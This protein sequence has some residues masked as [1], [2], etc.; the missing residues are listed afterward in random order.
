M[1]N[2]AFFSP[3]HVSG[4]VWSCVDAAVTVTSQ[5]FW[6]HLHI[7]RP[8][9]QTLW[10]QAL[11]EFC[12][13]NVEF[14]EIL[15]SVLGAACKL[16]AL[17]NNFSLHLAPKECFTVTMNKCI[18]QH[19]DTHKHRE[20]GRERVTLLHPATITTQYV[21]WA[22]TTELSKNQAV[23]LFANQDM[24][25]LVWIN[26]LLKQQQKNIVTYIHVQTGILSH[27]MCYS[28]P[29]LE[30]WGNTLFFSYLQ[31]TLEYRKLFP[32]D[33]IQTFMQN[34]WLMM[35]VLSFS[36]SAPLVLRF[37]DGAESHPSRSTATQSDRN[38]V[39]CTD[40]QFGG[41]NYLTM[42]NGPMTLIQ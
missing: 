6:W 12:S 3:I 24:A 27:S 5:D 35:T 20:R 2:F 21:C 22:S 30:V 25:L 42:L 29:P 11:W 41:N 19:T 36:T 17:C 16:Y 31:P 15:I 23:R 38:W 8:K 1:L 37:R 40:S 39:S 4:P 13:T 10:W 32:L 28:R 34:R 18:N 7:K 26:N 9:M 14:V 33:G